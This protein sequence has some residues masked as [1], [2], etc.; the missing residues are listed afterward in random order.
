LQLIGRYLALTGRTATSRYVGDAIFF[1]DSAAMRRRDC[2]VVV[3]HGCH[4]V[5][6]VRGHEAIKAGLRERGYTFQK[7]ADRIGVARATVVIVS[8]GHRRSRRIEGA[9]ADILEK[10]PEELW[11]ERYG[12]EAIE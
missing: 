11:P 7:V 6:Q 3:Y 12:K 2:E 8:Q 1:I 9:I 4:E 10:E 5:K